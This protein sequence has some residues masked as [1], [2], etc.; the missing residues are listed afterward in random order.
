MVQTAHLA[1]SNKEKIAEL[2][3]SSKNLNFGFYITKEHILKE[4]KTLKK[5]IQLKKIQESKRQ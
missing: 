2:L 1:F 5:I 4:I 3:E